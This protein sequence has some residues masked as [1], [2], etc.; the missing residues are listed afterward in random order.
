[1]VV[2][3]KI[4]NDWRM[5]LKRMR[6]AENTIFFFFLLLNFIAALVT[7][8]TGFYTGDAVGIQTWTS[9]T[10]QLV[11]GLGVL[12]CFLVNRALI[13]SRRSAKHLT[14]PA[15]YSEY[16]ISIILGIG[17]I[18]GGAGFVL[19]GYG[20]AEHQSS[21]A[22]GFVFKLV[23]YDLAFQ[24]ML[25]M[26]PPK[27][28]YM[29]LFLL[30]AALRL[31]MG[32]TSFIAFSF[33]MLFMRWHASKPRSRKFSTFVFLCL[34]GIYFV[35]PFIYSIK[36]LIRYGHFLDISYIESLAMLLGRMTA[37]GNALYVS[38]FAEGIRRMMQDTSSIFM[39]YADPVLAVLPRALLGLHF[40]PLET[41]LVNYMAGGF[42][43]GIVFYASELG[44]LLVM[45]N[46]HPMYALLLFGV[47][48]SLL[49]CNFK[50]LL[51]LCGLNGRFFCLMMG[52]SLVASGSL[53]EQGLMLYGL[54]V[55]NLFQMLL[56]NLV[57][58]LKHWNRVPYDPST[59]VGRHIGAT[60][61]PVN[62]GGN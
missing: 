24:L 15:R 45:W 60:P 22:F 6:P 3:A 23:P 56:V 46:A 33:F 25:C 11:A 47:A 21:A 28:K 50:L 7:Y 53:E 37:Y 29:L 38:E 49:Y 10:H 12:A 35:A 62:T 57:P 2:S 9:A 58:I 14:Q 32:W 40:E 54:L 19:F 31:L 36:F 17:L 8:I 26:A 18:L 43:P 41:V 20:A 34:A 61:G 1:M 5:S 27:K 30:Y 52:M 13:P 48:M 4:I 59:E 16:A 44:K 42:N 51:R 39:P 55:V